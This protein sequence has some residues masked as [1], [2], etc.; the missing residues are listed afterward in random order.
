MVPEARTISPPL[1][2]L[3]VTLLADMPLIVIVPPAA[4]L[5]ALP[6]E[7]FWMKTLSLSEMKM[8]RPAPA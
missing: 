5:I 6:A 7:R 1:V 8:L 3:K 2:V 4:T